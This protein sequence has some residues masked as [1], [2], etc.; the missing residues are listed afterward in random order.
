MVSSIRATYR[1]HIETS[2]RRHRTGIID[3]L[4]KDAHMPS[5]PPRN[6]LGI[7]HEVVPVIPHSGCGDGLCFDAECPTCWRLHELLWLDLSSFLPDMVMVE[8][9]DDLRRA[10]EAEA[11]RR[12]ETVD[13]VVGSIL[14]RWAKGKV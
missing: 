12:G 6:V 13:A 5:K 7:A 14:R 11:T 4:I 10:L 3:A 9:D 1:N 2:P 8:I